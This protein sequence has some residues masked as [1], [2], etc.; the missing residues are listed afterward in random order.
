LQNLNNTNG[1]VDRINNSINPYTISGQAFQNGSL[2][3]APAPLK[4]AVIY[5][6]QDS[7]YKNFGI[8]NSNGEYIAA[9][10]PP[11]TYTLTARRIGFAPVTQN[12][13]I[14]NSN[15]QNINFN[16]GSPIGIEVISL[17]VPSRFSLSQ[18]YPNPFNPVTNIKF[19][20]PKTGVVNLTVYDAAG[21]EAA[22]LFNG[23]LSEGTY[24][25][26]FDASQLA[27][28]IYFY[29]LEAGE[30]TQTKKMVLVK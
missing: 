1:Q 7:V 20:V 16:F 28:G 3:A 13:T 26:D 21:R 12:V 9:N 6:L 5:V 8:T 17:E 23:E 27:S 11:G 22:M 15:L 2:D 25:Y 4:N 10:L 19:S 18:N 30:F 14:T 29:R 24:N